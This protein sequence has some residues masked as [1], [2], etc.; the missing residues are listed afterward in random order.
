[1]RL[2]FPY[3][4]RCVA[5]SAFQLCLTNLVLNCRLMA[6]WVTLLLAAP[7][8]VGA[9][10]LPPSQAAGFEHV[11][12]VMMENRSFDHFFGWLP[13]ANGRQA[14]LSY[15][16]STGVSHP[17]HSLPPDCQGCGFLDPGHSYSDGRAQYHE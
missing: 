2:L 3:S 4:S 15:Q 14:G 12:V 13:G 17:A 11:V 9:D 8:L 6:L 5:K 16:D 7:L 1:M 10:S